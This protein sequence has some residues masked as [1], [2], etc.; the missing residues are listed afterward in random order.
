MKNPTMFRSTSEPPSG[1]RGF[2]KSVGA[3]AGSAGLLGLDAGFVHA[4]P[5]PEK[6]RIRLGKTPGICIARNTSPKICCVPRDLA[7]SVTSRRKQ[8]R[9]SR[10]RWQPAKST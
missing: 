4:E 10:K 2:M 8:A 9:V 6:T 7:R 3:L 1:R 5:P